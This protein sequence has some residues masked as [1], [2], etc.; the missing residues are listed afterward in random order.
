MTSRVQA[1]P[2]VY[3]ALRDATVAYLVDNCQLVSH[4]VADRP[5]STR[6]AFHGPTHGSAIGASQPLDHGSGT[7]CRPGFA[8]GPF[9]AAAVWAGQ[10]GG[11]IFV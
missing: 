8:T 10:W 5:T 11:H 6:A 4:A 9:L 3:K 2:L 7:I 1:G